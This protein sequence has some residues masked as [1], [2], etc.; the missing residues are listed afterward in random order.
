MLLSALAGCAAGRVNLWPIYFRETRLVKGADG[1][2][3]VTTTEFLYPLFTWESTSE[4]SWHAVRP[5]YNYEHSKSEGTHRVQ[6]LWPL[7]LHFKDGTD[8][9]HHRLFPLFEHIKSYSP[10][11][12]EHAVHAH[13]LQLLRWGRDDRWG[14]YVA[15][16]PLA[17]VTH[18]VISDTWSFVAF[19]LYSHYRHGDYVR[20]DFPW[21]FIGYGRTPDG[22]KKTYRLWPFFVSQVK[23]LSRESRSRYDLLWP[24]IRWGRLDRG[25]KYYHTVV[26]VLPFYSAVSTYDRDG[27]LVSCLRS[28]LGVFFCTGTPPGG[29]RAG[30][31]AL[32]SLARS[33]RTAKQDEFRILP[34]YSRTTR[35]ADSEKDPERS[36][37]R[38]RILWPLIWLDS[39]R[40]DPEHGKGGVVVALYWH[41]TDTYP[42]ENG[43]AL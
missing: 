41:Y 32:W 11:T 26:A 13:L 31:S 4:T 3:E 38:R 8:L 5:L 2:R 12:K 24:L 43:P 7:G 37:V 34:F 29:V 21:P 25:G 28:V 42:Q 19:P 10:L 16:F 39:D 18:G 9:T 15:L 1:P 27:R 17:G 20:D 22:G 14:P 35:Y 40:R 36:W 6:Y 33:V 23:K 30:W